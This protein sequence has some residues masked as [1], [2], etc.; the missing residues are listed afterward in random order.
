[1]E[2]KEEKSRA[3][4]S[5]GQL[6]AL[7]GLREADLI[8][9]EEEALYRNES[10]RAKVQALETLLSKAEEGADERLAASRQ[11]LHDAVARTCT[12]TESVFK[13]ETIRMWRCATS[14]C[15]AERKFEATEQMAS[16][17]E[18]S[19]TEMSIHLCSQVAVTEATS[20][21]YALY[22]VIAQ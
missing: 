7:Q 5:R 3:E 19:R 2:A 11:K 10:V 22:R 9:A 21:K 16:D 6:Q 20:A 18:R 8:R 14:I 4:D 17:S 13:R 12:R 1:V 15:A